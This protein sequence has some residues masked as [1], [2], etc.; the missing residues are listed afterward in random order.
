V[1]TKVTDGKFHVAI[2]PPDKPFTCIPRDPP[3]A[4][5]AKATFLP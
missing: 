1:I 4:A 2:A 5:T 3:D